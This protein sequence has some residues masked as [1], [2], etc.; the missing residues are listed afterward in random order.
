MLNRIVKIS[1]LAI[2]T[3]AIAAATIIP[4][5]P[6]PSGNGIAKAIPMCPFPSGNGIA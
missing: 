4:M 6:F 1:V 5:C 2:A 3:L